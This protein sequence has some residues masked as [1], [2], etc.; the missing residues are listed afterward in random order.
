[1]TK[2]LLLPRNCTWW[3][4]GDPT[5]NPPE[6]QEFLSEMAKEFATY[7]GSMGLVGAKTQTRDVI[8]IH[9]GRGRRWE[10]TLAEN[11]ADVHVTLLTLLPARASAAIAW[12]RGEPLETVRQ[13][14]EG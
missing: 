7:I 13:L 10:L 3:K 14:L 9:R 4:R 2:D 6:D 8:V 12:L 5:L 1:M 11:K